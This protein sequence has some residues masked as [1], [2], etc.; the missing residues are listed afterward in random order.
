MSDNINN[1]IKNIRLWIS[2]FKGDQTKTLTL[3][4]LTFFLGSANHS[5]IHGIRKIIKKNKIDKEK[6]E[7]FINFIKWF[8]PKNESVWEHV[9][10]GYFPLLLLT[11]IFDKNADYNSRIIG[12]WAHIITM[13]VLFYLYVYYI[14]GEN[15]LFLDIILYFIC[16]LSGYNVEQ[17]LKKKKIKNIKT[18]RYLTLFLTSLIII[19][20]Y[21]DHENT[22]NENEGVF[23]LP[24]SVPNK[25]YHIF[26][27]FEDKLKNNRYLYKK[28]VNNK[29]KLNY[30]DQQE[31]VIDGNNCKGN[32]RIPNKKHNH[33][34]NNHSNKDKN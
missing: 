1:D 28:C 3:W 13:L 7:I 19:L 5:F 15:K 20:S 18:I 27:M 8:S 29:K 26:D 12:L 4:I 21:I 16:C 22:I 9:K 30:N 10:M 23:T 33:N 6:S 24:F 2:K 25:P 32:Y 34:D 14:F 11:V 31:F 17:S